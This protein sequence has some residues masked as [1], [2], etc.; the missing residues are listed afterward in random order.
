MS[1]A[2]PVPEQPELGLDDLRDT[3][4]RADDRAL[5]ADAFRRLRAADGFSHARSIAFLTSLI[6]VQ[7]VIALVGLAHAFSAGSFGG[8]IVD[9]LDSVVPGAANLL[10]REAVEQA[11]STPVQTAT[12]WLPLVLGTLGA[13]VTGTTLLGQIERATNRTYGIERDRPT[14]RKYG[15]AAV[16][17]LTA[18]GLAVLAFAIMTFGRQ[19]SQGR[20]PTALPTAW[21]LVRWPLA[22]VLFAAATAAVYRWSPRRRQPRWTWLLGGAIVS[23]AIF[24]VVTLIFDALF[25]LSSTFGATYGPLA[26]IIALS[27]WSYAV[28]LGLLFGA[29]LSAQ[30]EAVR[31]GVPGPTRE[32]ADD[33]STWTPT[34]RADTVAVP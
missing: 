13:L 27:L 32:T 23:V 29:A 31:A 22:A 26:G 4:K 12:A 1:T 21:N 30:A 7:A 17:C 25:Q 2:R 8:T 19:L 5:V 14:L 11:R 6:F 15:R 20:E 9:T 3:L 28:S 24:T 33:P 18:G 16:L 10:L 34:D